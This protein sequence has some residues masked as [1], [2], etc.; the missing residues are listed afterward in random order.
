M[1][2]IKRITRDHLIKAGYVEQKKFAKIIGVSEYTVS[3]MKSSGKIIFHPEYNSMIDKA[4]SLEKLRKNHFIDKDLKHKNFYKNQ[5][6]TKSLPIESSLNFD[7]NIKTSSLNEKELKTISEKQKE[8]FLKYGKE[9]L[10][11]EC[12]IDQE[13]LNISELS[14]SNTNNSMDN[15]LDLISGIDDPLKRTQIIKDYW[16]GKILRIKFIKEQNK[17]IAVNEAKPLL[18]ILYRPIDEG[19]EKMII[20][21]QDKFPEISKDAIIWLSQTSKTMK[22]SINNYKWDFDN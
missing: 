13:D 8:E 21:I 6:D 7:G 12:E 14:S 17:L 4:K 20:D 11:D 2:R 18:K 5:T 3:D 1:S 10:N 19:M 9:L 15:I 16:T 22:E